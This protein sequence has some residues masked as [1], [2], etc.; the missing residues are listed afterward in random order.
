MAFLSVGMCF[1]AMP[2]GT[3]MVA[4]R[5]MGGEKALRVTSRLESAHDAFP[6]SCRLVRIFG[7]VIQPFVLPVLDTGQNL[8]LRCPIAGKLIR[9][10]HARDV[11]AALE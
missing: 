1:Q 7:P 3:A 11:Q 9:D 4:N 5:T 8:A 2:M 10:D 6:L